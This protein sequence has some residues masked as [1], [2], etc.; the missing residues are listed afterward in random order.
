VLAATDTGTANWLDTAGRP[1]LL[2]TVR[3]F[4]PP[5]P[6]PIRSEIVPLAALDEHLPAE[7]RHVDADARADELRGRS[8]HVSWRYRT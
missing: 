4:R 7:H 1:E 3:W 2:T 6:P 8:A 5:E